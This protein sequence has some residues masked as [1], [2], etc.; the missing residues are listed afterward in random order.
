VIGEPV[1]LAQDSRTRRLLVIRLVVFWA[2]L[3]MGAI[4]LGALL[5]GLGAALLPRGSGPV[6]IALGVLAGLVILRETVGRRIPIPQIRWQVPREWLRNPW[7]GAVAFGSIMGMGVFTRQ[8]SAL[9][10]L[11]VLGCLCSGSWGR[12]ALLGLVYGITYVSTFAR[13]LAYTRVGEPGLGVDWVAR[14]WTRVRWVG[15]T[16]A[17]LIV[18]V[19]LA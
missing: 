16:A 13:G 15:V 8:R 18:L 3:L 14:T 9:F 4:A 11:Y 19:P 10:H 2:A 6:A 7:A 17:P 12:G 1:W 5:G